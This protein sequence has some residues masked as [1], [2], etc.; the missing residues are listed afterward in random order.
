MKICAASVATNDYYPVIDRYLPGG[1]SFNF[2]AQCAALG[3][4]ASFA[5]AVGE[6][7]MGRWISEN[8]QRLGIDSSHLYIKPGNTASNVLQI[9]EAGERFNYPEDWHGGV[10]EQFRFSDEDWRFIFSHDAAMIT[11]YDPNIKGFL[12]HIRPGMH[13]TIDCLD[14]PKTDLLR[15]VLP[16]VSAVQFSAAPEFENEVFPLSLEYDALIIHT[17]DALGSAAFHKGRKYHQPAIPVKKVIDTTGCGDT[18]HASFTCRY[19][20]GNPI[21]HCLLFAAR[22][23]AERLGHYGGI[24]I[25]DTPV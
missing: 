13:T 10:Y 20:E 22:Q 6:D 23:A 5:G 25:N 19:L 7:R 17:R 9:T 12:K 11:L 4:A 3:H 8:S 2:A 14:N 18:F 15:E 16:L 21:E 1:N 24:K